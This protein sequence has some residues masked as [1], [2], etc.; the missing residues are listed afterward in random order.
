METYLAQFILILKEQ[1][2][3]VATDIR[4]YALQLIVVCLTLELVRKTY[5]ILILGENG[6]LQYGLFALRSLLVIELFLDFPNIV[7]TCYD[8]AVRIGVLAGGAGIT[9]ADFQDGGMI[10]KQSFAIGD[11]MLSSAK[12]QFGITSLAVGIILLGSWLVFTIAFALIAVTI[13]LA[14]VELIV[15]TPL[16]LLLLAFTLC[17]WTAWMGKNV[18]SWLF[19]MGGTFLVLAMGSSMVKP[20]VQAIHIGTTTDVGE[21]MG[22][23]IAALAIAC[24][25]WRLPGI[26]STLFGGAPAMD[27]SAAGRVASAGITGAYLGGSLMN[28]RV[29]GSIGTLGH[30]TA[31][32]IGSEL[33]G[34]AGLALA[35]MKS[36]GP[37]VISATQWA[38]SMAK[39][40]NK[41]GP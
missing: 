14:Q 6:P 19:K 7:T 38:V 10:L 31:R 17:G 16:C 32:G 20:L 21:A 2:A 28:N 1:F 24:F 13:F 29:T 9:F 12:E 33:G 35:Q 5:R 8:Y 34:A 36:V 15:L 41:F 22:L 27:F 30:H 40:T 18:F 23:A 4:P 3:H 39:R 37:P 25:F 26:I 11:V